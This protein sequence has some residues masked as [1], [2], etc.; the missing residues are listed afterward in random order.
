MWTSNKL[1]VFHVD[2]GAVENWLLQHK[3][4]QN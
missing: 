1:D 2:L 3:H 4:N